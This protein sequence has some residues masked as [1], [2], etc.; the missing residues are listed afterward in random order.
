MEIYA[1]PTTSFSKRVLFYLKGMEEKRDLYFT[2]L[3][4]NP[5]TLTLKNWGANLTGSLLELMGVEKGGEPEILA[6]SGNYSGMSRVLEL[7]PGH[8]MAFRVGI[9][10]PASET[11]ETNSSVW[12]ETQ[13]Q[14][15]DVKFKFRVA[16]GSLGTVP[17]EL[18]FEPAFP[19][20]IILK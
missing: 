16:K 9:F 5:V 7:P 10:T 14:R 3:N 6:R 18:V 12:L 8:F 17:S 20:R 11:G 1:Y 2:V 13:F 15:L 4:K 19:V